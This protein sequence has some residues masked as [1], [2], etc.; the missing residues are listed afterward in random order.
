MEANQPILSA[1]DLHREFPTTEGMLSVLKGVTLSIERGDMIA[2]TGPSG[3]GKSTLLHLLGGLDRP[4]QGEVYLGGESL[5]GKS[6]RAL[7][8]LRN[9][10]VGFVF[11]FHYLLDDFTARENVMIPMLLAGVNPREATERAEL[12]LA[13]VSL[14]D[15]RSHRPQQLSGGEQQRVAVARA[16]ANEPEVVL[17]DEPS[18]NLDTATGRKLHELMLRL[19]AEKSTSFVIATHN[20]ELARQCDRELRLADGRLVD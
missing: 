16:L 6:E 7:A 14:T 4:T 13:E 19:N 11:Q 2:V 20:R 12:L 8:A 9:R 5:A 18:G 3:V 1:I 15:R 17:A 10:K